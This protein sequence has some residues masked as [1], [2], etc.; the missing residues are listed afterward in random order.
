MLTNAY[1]ICTDVSRIKLKFNQR[2]SLYQVVGSPKLECQI[3]PIQAIN[4]IGNDMSVSMCKYQCS[5]WCFIGHIIMIMDFSVSIVYR[6][7]N[8]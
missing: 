3:F 2:R 7:H 1:S 4:T 5:V 6:Q 8:R